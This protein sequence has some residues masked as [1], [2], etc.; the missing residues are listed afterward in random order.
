MKTIKKMS[1]HS[2]HR[3]KV[4]EKG[5]STLTKQNGDR[6]VMGSARDEA[7]FPIAPPR[8][9]L[10]RNYTETLHD[11]KKRIQQERLRTVMAANS[12][13]V[14]LYWDIGRTILARQETA[15]W[16]A[17]V[18]DR[19]SSDLRDAFPDMKGFSPRNLKYMR[20]FAAAWPDRAF[21]QQAAAQMPWFH[22]CVL[23]DR[24]RKP[25]DRE[26]YIRQTIQNGWSRN[27]L[28]IQI[29]GRL[30]ERQGKAIT[31]FPAILPPADSACAFSITSL[32]PRKVITAFRNLD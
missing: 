16:G 12:A 14:L 15:G 32:L 30:H 29:E 23:L 9:G 13:M 26:W 18:I 27:I 25:S 19:L 21:V 31:N 10:P 6:S 7:M 11:L 2:R 24:V 3:E 4:R 8:A 20:T 22:N 17:R 1:E 28:A 5:A